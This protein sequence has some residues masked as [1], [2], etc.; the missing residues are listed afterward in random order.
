VSYTRVT[1]LE[2]SQIY[3]LRQAGKGSNEIARLKASHDYVSHTGGK[4]L[5]PTCEWS[6]TGYL[7]VAFDKGSAAN[8]SKA[9][10]GG[11]WPLTGCINQKT[12]EGH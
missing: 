9:N 3:V 2:R 11:C 5:W 1:E 8:M 7:N 12:E 4:S 10:A 6:E